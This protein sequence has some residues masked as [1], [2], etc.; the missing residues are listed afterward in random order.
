MGK[1]ISIETAMKMLEASQKK[2][3]E[4]GR[5]CSISI[6]D[7]AGYML[8][9]ARMDGAKRITAE[10]AQ[11]K[12]WTG[13]MF[14][15]GTGIMRQMAQP[16]NAGFGINSID[17]RIMLIAGGHPIRD[18]EEVIGGIGA[19]G[20]VTEEEDEAVAVAAFS[21]TDYNYAGAPTALDKE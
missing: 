20:G 18:G 21:V 13:A 17:P 6:V 3:A 15:R 19:S 14:Q 4:L 12:A 2:S 8:A 16:G 1:G 11:K 5:L 9:F 10:I 7:D